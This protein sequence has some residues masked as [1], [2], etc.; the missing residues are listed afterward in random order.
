MDITD[1]DSEEAEQLEAQPKQRTLPSDL[2]TSLD[3]R[4]QDTLKPDI[5][6]YDDWSGQAPRRSN[7]FFT[8]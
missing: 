1:H 4:R 8:G 6:I 5:E 3:D 2:P 7:S